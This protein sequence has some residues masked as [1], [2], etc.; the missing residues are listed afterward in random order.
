MFAKNKC[1]IINFIAICLFILCYA[2]LTEQSAA[3]IPSSQKTSYIRVFLEEVEIEYD[4]KP[5]I[6]S[7]R[8]L[9]PM[10]FTFESMGLDIEWK[11]EEQVITGSTDTFTIIF[12]VGSRRVFLGDGNERVLDVPPQIIENRTLI[13]LRFLSESL[14]YN[15]SWN[16]DSNVILISKEPIVEWRNG[17]YE[18][19]YPFKELEIK[20]VNGEKTSDFRYTGRTKEYLTEWKI[21][22]YETVTP[23]KE[24]ER[25]YIDGVKTNETRY[26]GRTKEVITE[27]KI[28]GYETVAPYKEYERLYINGVKSNETRYTG[29][30]KPEENRIE[31]VS[32]SWEYPLDWYTWSFSLNIPVKAVDF[33][34]DFNRNYVLS[35]SYYVS[36]EADDDYM[37]SLAQ[38]FVNTAENEGLGEW[39]LIELAVSFVQSLD[40]VSDVIGTGYDEYAKFPLETLYDKSGDCEDSSILLASILRELGYG[41]VL[42]STDTHMGVGLKTSDKGNFQYLGLEFYYIETTGVG[43]EIGDLPDEM[44][45]VKIKILP[46]W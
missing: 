12:K 11:A 42:V 44:A 13:P 15:V 20:F 40:Y 7:G 8:T 24:F 9:V 28:E 32:Y 38:M 39:E 5:Q 23:Y 25:L 41:T 16:G 46:T 31:K 17:G 34:R 4:V 37:N 19:S 26:T 30:T 22:G 33:Y 36:H 45:G 14:G 18:S 43:W 35:Y 6:I 29:N 2:N 1:C 21:E 3:A 27:W 10:R